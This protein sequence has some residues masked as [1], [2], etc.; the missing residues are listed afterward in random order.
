METPLGVARRRAAAVAEHMT[1][2]PRLVSHGAAPRNHVGGGRDW[3]AID[4]AIPDRQID[5]ARASAVQAAFLAKLRVSTSRLRCRRN[6]SE[7]MKPPAELM[8]MQMQRRSHSEIVCRNGENT[9][10]VHSV[11]YW[12]QT[13]IRS[14][15]SAAMSPSSN[16]S[17]GFHARV[18]GL[19]L[20]AVLTACLVLNAASPSTRAYQQSNRD[21]GT[22]GAIS[23]SASP[24]QTPGSGSQAAPFSMNRSKVCAT[25]EDGY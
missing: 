13:G 15:S 9:A 23:V 20:A 10:M 21:L 25:N 22:R 24:A 2:S 12:D 18:F 7:N 1:R 17:A 11:S 3:R 4:R 19:S 5:L 6:L 14:H 16:E 8:N